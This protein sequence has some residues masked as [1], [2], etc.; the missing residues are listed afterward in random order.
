MKWI[1]HREFVLA[2]QTVNSASYCD[3]LWWLH[4]NSYTNEVIMTESQVVLNT[5]TEHN[6]Q[7]AFKNRRSIL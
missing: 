4:E 6:F 2:D 3:I 7:N 1:V 5:L